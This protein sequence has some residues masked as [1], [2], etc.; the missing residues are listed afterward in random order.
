MK[1]TVIIGHGRSP[2]GKG[3]GE[4]IDAADVVIRMWDCGWQSEED[5][6]TKYD[7]GFYEIAP[8][9]TEKV[10]QF[11]KREPSRAW[12][13]SLLFKRG[14]VLPYTFQVDQTE[15]NNRCRRMGGIG[16]TGRLQFTRGTI[17]ACW[18]ITQLE[19]GDA[20]VLVGYDVIR[21]GITPK[22]EEAFSPE[23]RRNPGTFSFNGWVADQTKFGNHDYA[24]ER[25]FLESMA[26]SRGISLYF[27]QDV[28]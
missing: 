27:A 24:I 4:K 2:E 12:I 15:W 10:V 28:W 17:A 11:R 6:G 25:P 3:W 5:Y 1:Q 16:K 13:G 22:V 23:Y 19:E 20:V 21:V 8:G 14:K 26:T 18:A 9:L 7:F